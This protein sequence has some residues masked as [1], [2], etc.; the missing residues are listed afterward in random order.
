MH[1]IYP[2]LQNIKEVSPL[3]IYLFVPAAA[4][5]EVKTLHCAPA[6]T[7]FQSNALPNNRMQM[8]TINWISD[9]P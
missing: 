9:E 7:R 1:V 6:V 5:L 3:F 8:F 2:Y 4:K